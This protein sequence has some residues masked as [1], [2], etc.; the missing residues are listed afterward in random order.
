VGNHGINNVQRLEIKRS[1][2]K[3]RY[4]LQQDILNAKIIMID[5]KKKRRDEKAV[6][7]RKLKFIDQCSNQESSP[8]KLF[9]NRND[10]R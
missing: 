8:D 7:K 10:D 5:P 9:K 6:K 1:P 4:H 3:P 2:N